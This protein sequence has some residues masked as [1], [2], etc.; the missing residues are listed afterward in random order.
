[1]A[2]TT[3]KRCPAMHG[4]SVRAMAMAASDSKV[5]VSGALDG[6]FRS[7]NGGNSWERISPASQA[8]IKNIES[9]AIDPKNPE[10]GVCG[11]LAPGVEDRRRRR[12]LASHQQG[13]D[14]RLGRVLGHRGLHQSCGGLCQRLLRNLQERQRRRSFPQDAGHSVFRAP[15]PRAEAGPEQSG[16]RFMPGPPKVCGR[17]MDVGK[18]WKRVSNPE[19][20]VNDVLVDP[21]NSNRVLLATDRSGVLASDNGAQTLA[22]SNHGYTHRYVTLDSGRPERS[23][24][25]LGGRGE[26]SRVWRRLLHPRWRTELAAEERGPGR[27]R[28]FHACSRLATAR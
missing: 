14:R 21:R 6:V 5:L 18:T 12:Q 23:Q 3:G 15:H 13:H 20:V 26:R 28:C 22:A 7:K 1:M 24:Q 2:A 17:P 19:V 16:T 27:T 10:R 4:K 8:E 11:N 9:I 25:H